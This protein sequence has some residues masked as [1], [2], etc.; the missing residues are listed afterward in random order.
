MAPFKRVIYKT[1]F[2]DGDYN[3][4]IALAMD[5]LLRWYRN[6]HLALLE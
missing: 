1:V 3:H 5:V 2:V 6:P 4:R